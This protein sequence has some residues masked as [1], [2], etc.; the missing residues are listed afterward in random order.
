MLQDTN[1]GIVIILIKRVKEIQCLLEVEREKASYI[2]VC[3]M[4]ENIQE[5]LAGD[6]WS[7]L[8]LSRQISVVA[9]VVEQ[10]RAVQ[11]EEIGVRETEEKLASD[12]AR[13]EGKGLD[14]E[15]LHAEQ[16][17]ECAHVLER[18]GKRELQRRR[19]HGSVVQG[20]P[21]RYGERQGK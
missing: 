6:A 4:E 16:D 1:F 18:Q 5:H 17:A 12:L 11:V 3:V 14:W 7:S 19:G 2:S 13:K 9:Y 15:L 8:R 20:T 10:G 21:V